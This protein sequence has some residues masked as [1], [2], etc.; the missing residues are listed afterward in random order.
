MRILFITGFN[1][2]PDERGGVN[3]YKVFE[4]YYRNSPDKIEFFRYKTY[5]KGDEVLFRLKT[6]IHANNYDM[7]ISHSMGGAL[8]Y[9][10]LNDDQ[11]TSI[12]RKMERVVL[13]MPM[14]YIDPCINLVVNFTTLPDIPVPFSLIVPNNKLVSNESVATNPQLVICRQI[15]YAY[16]NLLPTSPFDAVFTFNSYPNVRLMFATNDT[17]TVPLAKEYIR[18]INRDQVFLLHDGLHEGFRSPDTQEQFFELFEQMI[19]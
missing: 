12:L 2:H 4:L 7:I 8:I 14:L 5:E 19:E 6:Q 13:L 15:K 11:T 10:L 9:R 17:V 3:P 1:T 18:K 16:N